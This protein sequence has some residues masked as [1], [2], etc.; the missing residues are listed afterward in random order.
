MQKEKKLI[1]VGYVR[2][3][4]N[5]QEKEGHSIDAQ[6][7][8]I[9]KYCESKGYK[10]FDTYVDVCSGSTE[11]LKRDG[12]NKINT[13][14]TGKKCQGVV[15]TKYDRLGRDLVDVVTIMK[16]YF[17]KND[18]KIFFTD[19]QATDLN[20]IEGMFQFNMLATV[21]ELERGM[22]S[23]RTK[24]IMDYKKS[25]SDK[26]GGCIK[27]GY[28]I[29]EVK[30]GNKII[31]KLVKNTEEIELIEEMKSLK[32]NENYTYKDICK[33]LTDRKIINRS[34]KV[35]WTPI[36]IM[37]MICPE[38]CPNVKKTVSA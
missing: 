22:I 26:L 11:C 6:K 18:Y 10:L 9:N 35:E 28:K 29:E 34:G 14:L 24:H 36:K 3:S 15:M 21:S 16:N 12:F 23:K 33:I 37:R 17:K 2:I 27:Y 7:Q 13:L 32:D 30:E 31:K 19:F 38:K 4:T 20:S 8:I 5:K 1:V 25:K